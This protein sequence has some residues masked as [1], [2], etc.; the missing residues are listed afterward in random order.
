MT[1]GKDDDGVER[2]EAEEL[3][4]PPVPPPEALGNI[5]DPARDPNFGLFRLGVNLVTPVDHL[6]PASVSEVTGS[7]S[8]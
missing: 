1:G 6:E 2:E 3:F 5:P 7:S 8:S 4:P